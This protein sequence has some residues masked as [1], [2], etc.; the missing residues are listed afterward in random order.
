MHEIGSSLLHIF[1]V[2][3]CIWP[4]LNLMM[5]EEPVLH[6]WTL[7][8][9][10]EDEHSSS[11]HGS[12]CHPQF[13]VRQKGQVSAG[14]GCAAGGLYPSAWLVG[15][16]VSG[17]GMGQGN[18]LIMMMMIDWTG[19]HFSHREAMLTSSKCSTS[20][21][22]RHS[23]LGNE[24][25]RSNMR[26]SMESLTELG[27]DVHMW[28]LKSSFGWSINPN[29]Y[30]YSGGS[31][32]LLVHYTHKYPYGVITGRAKSVIGRLLPW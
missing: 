8:R 28:L 7:C 17:E 6:A 27:D 23:L 15:F 1:W 26:M 32:V 13:W 31:V 3:M 19:L 10:W 25:S 9:R 5:P 12:E 29:F 4:L 30:R 18:Q 20:K 2:W 22:V 16:S 24:A 14:R 11:K 21:C